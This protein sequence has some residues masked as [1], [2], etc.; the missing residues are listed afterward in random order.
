VCAKEAKDMHTR[1]KNTAN[2]HPIR[3]FKRVLSQATPHAR[4]TL[5][6]FSTTTGAP[7][8]ASCTVHVAVTASKNTLGSRAI[9][10]PSI[11]RNFCTC[12]R[13][14]PPARAYAARQSP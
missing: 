3:R 2:S 6:F 12:M 14:P 13:P 9:T 4:R 7:P 11:D 10:G 8:G 5:G 1:Y